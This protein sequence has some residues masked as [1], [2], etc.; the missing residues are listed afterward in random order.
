MFYEIH[1]KDLW[2]YALHLDPPNQLT[3]QIFY[4]NLASFIQ[5]QGFQFPSNTSGLSADR[6]LGRT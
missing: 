3:P 1:E 4:G 6:T 2:G 5:T